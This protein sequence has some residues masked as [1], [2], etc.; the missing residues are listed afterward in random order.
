MVLSSRLPLVAS[1][2]VARFQLEQ[3]AE[4][5]ENAA[6]QAKELRS[7]IARIPGLQAPG[8]QLLE[9]PG[10][11]AWDPT[12]LV[13]NVRGLGIT[14]FEAAEWLCCERQILVEMADF[15]NLV[16]IL[17]PA[18]S[19]FYNVLLD[20]L[21]SLA[22]SCG[23][24][25]ERCSYPD[26]LELPFPRQVMTPR[27]AFFAPRSSLSWEDAAGKVAAEVVAPYP[28]G[29]PVLCP[30][31]KISQEVLEFLAEWEAAGGVWPGWSQ[32]SIKVVTGS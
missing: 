21:E 28:P 31:E 3:E 20:G 18:D 2:D 17:G 14:G 1:L 13:V 26:P 5:W 22:A 23:S 27:E 6:R 32:H 25:T 30:G 9:V 29:I 11:D 7:Q 24:G 8:D 19:A 16:F 10:V 4:P 12:R 15:Q